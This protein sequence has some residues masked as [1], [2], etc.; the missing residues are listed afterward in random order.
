MIGAILSPFPP[1]SPLPVL[2]PSYE[3]ATSSPESSPVT[4]PHY[5]TYPSMLH[6]LRETSCFR[7]IT[8]VKLDPKGSYFY[9]RMR[10]EPHILK[11]DLDGDFCRSFG[12]LPESGSPGNGSLA[13]D[14][15]DERD[16]LCDVSGM[17]ISRTNRLGVPIDMWI[18]QKLLIQGAKTLGPVAYTPCKDR[19]VCVD[20]E[21]AKVL[22]VDPKSGEVC[23]TIG[24][25]VL[26]R[27]RGVALTPGPQVT[28]VVTD[29]ATHQLK[30]FTLKGKAIGALGSFG[31]G[32]G[33]MMHPTGAC[34]DGEGRILVCDHCNMR[35]VRWSQAPGGWRWECVVT[36]EQLGFRYPTHV[37]VSTSGHIIVGSMT[38]QPRMYF[39][40]LF[41]GYK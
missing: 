6:G 5:V 27:P 4:S 7:P 16:C 25:G 23:R 20:V 13:F 10:D 22:V 39:W 30:L 24:A 3:E 14:T 31:T 15:N 40:T 2:P 1:A 28:I 26:G 37:D 12:T 29:H 41:T 17:T 36:Q 35:V 11:Y 8:D 32:Y 18:P 21:E 19:Y 33:Q 9:V 34:V 38:S